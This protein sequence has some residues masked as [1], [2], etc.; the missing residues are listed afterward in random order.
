MTDADDAGCAYHRIDIKGC[1]SCDKKNRRG[2]FAEDKV[3][4]TPDALRHRI[5]SMSSA[6]AEK[7]I[8]SRDEAIRHEAWE[9]GRAAVRYA[10][11]IGAEPVNPY[12]KGGG[13]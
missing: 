2:R 10:L 11:P 9:E 6:Q 13:K 1:F 7:L 12:R 5:W 4:L 3:S 8:E